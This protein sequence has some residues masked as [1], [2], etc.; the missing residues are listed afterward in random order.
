MNVSKNQKD[1]DTFIS[2]ALFAFR[3]SP[4]ETTRESPFYLLYGREPRLPMDVS[5]LP[6]TD[7][8]SSIAEHHR[9]IVKQIELG[10]HI[11]H[12]NTQRAQQKMKAQYDK[13][14]QEPNFLEGQHVWVFTPK[15][16]KGLLRKL[17]H[18]WHGPYQIVEQLS[19]V[20]YQLRTCSNRLVTT[21][22]HE[23]RMKTFYDPTD[24]SIHRQTTF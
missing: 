7:P 9:R 13:I 11:A 21:T 10:Q 22:A 2:A 24:Q 15:T 19:P 12:E 4:S 23:N 14:A 3:T 17:L 18:K 6:P 5:L 20:H 8:T 1:W 16:F